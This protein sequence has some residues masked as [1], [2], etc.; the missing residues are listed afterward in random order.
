M[1]AR[2]LQHGALRLSL[3]LMLGALVI[4]G[5]VV[6]PVLFSHADSHQQAGMLA[7]VIFHQCNQGILVLA[8]AVAA[9]YWQLGERRKTCWLPLL[10]VVVL[11]AA[12]AFYVAPMI[13]QIK[14]AA[15]AIEA[16][17]EDDPQRASFAAWHGISA[18]LHLL[19]SLAAAWLVAAGSPRRELTNED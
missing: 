13:E 10:L 2:C 8:L 12:N 18:V 4:S 11:V 16:L 3:A 1:N 7:G 15:G 5:Y 9:F 6:A 17:A 14:H 19:A